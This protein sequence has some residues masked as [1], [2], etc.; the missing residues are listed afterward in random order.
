MDKIDALRAVVSVA[1]LGS[2][3]QA[4]RRLRW[5]P[6]AVTR[7]VAQ[8]ERELGV[9]LFDRN[10]RSVRLTERG[11]IFADR[12]RRILLELEESEQ[13]TRGDRVSPRGV[14]TVS[15]PML[16]GRLHVQP[17]VEQLLEK[18]AGLSVRLLLS[19]RF[20]LMIDEGIDVAVRIGKLGGSAFVA[21]EVG[22]VRRVLAASPAYLRKHG[23]PRAPADLSQHS[24]I[25][26]E[27]L[28]TTE[29]WHFG[30][31]ESLSV[32]VEPRLAVTSAESAIDAAERGVGIVR[33]LS[34]Q[35]SPAIRERRLKAVLEDFAPE[36]I[37]VHIV[38][39]PSRRGS[40]NV[41]AFVDHA[42]EQLKRDLL[43]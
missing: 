3:A 36:A 43:G 31:D 10:T 16:F 7:G 15:A 13:L 14:L 21:V 4:A 37:P 23:V 41:R 35:V 24:L 20:A 22:Q 2:F 34:Y 1:D 30:R 18:H 42:R 27:G 6:T 25:Q 33:A 40:A 17:I 11:A 8:I 9:V 19:D 26:F 38:Y 5:S 12:S 32:R 29:Q 39:S 28:E